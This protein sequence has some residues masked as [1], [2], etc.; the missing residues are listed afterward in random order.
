FQLLT[1]VGGSSLAKIS[2]W[3]VFLSGLAGR[4]SI[5]TGVMA[6]LR[7]ALLGAFASPVA[8]IGSL[9]KGIAGLARRLTGLPAL[10]GVIKVGMT[11]LG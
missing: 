4:V 8:A 3:G 2:G 9:L 7:G 11:A 6:P 10:F 1:T 5:L